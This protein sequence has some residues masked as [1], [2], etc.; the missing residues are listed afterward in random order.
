[1]Q[2]YLGDLEKHLFTYNKPFRLEAGGELKTLEIEYETLGQISSSGDNVIWVCHALTANADV[3]SWWPGC[4]G[5]GKLYDPSKHFIICANI[6]G[7]CYGSTG[8]LSINPETGLPYFASFPLVTMRDIVNAFDLLRQYLRIDQIHTCVGG[9]LG[10][11]QALEWVIIQ[12]SVIKNLVLM[13]TNAIHSPWGIAL[14]E[15]QR[16]AI[17]ADPTWKDN[18]PDAGQNGLA[19]ARAIALLSYRNYYTYKKSQTDQDFNKVSGFKA[20]TYQQ[21]Q[22]KKLVD[23]FN[24]ASYWTLTLALDSHNVG[25]NRGGVQKALSAIVANTLVIGIKSDILFPVEEQV[26]IAENIPHSYF[27]EF[28]S[29]YGHDGFLIEY[30][31]ITKHIRNFYEKISLKELA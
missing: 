23:R 20:T 1:M 25:R 21:Y 4:I 19:A 18:R 28:D 24:V 31:T 22:G 14:N 11:Q 15:T 5:Y 8:P 10:G 12:P 7:S 9:S 2:T 26:F 30:E 13:A 27:V 29:D 17:E 3:E 6:I 16:M